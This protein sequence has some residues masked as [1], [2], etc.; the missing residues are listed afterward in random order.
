VDDLG[1]PHRRH[2]TRIVGP[3][4][5]TFYAVDPSTRMPFAEIP[6]TSAEQVA[7]MAED[8]RRALAVE[9]EWREPRVRAQVLGALARLA[10]EHAEALAELECR[11]TGTPPTR[12]RE[13]VAAAVS[14][15]EHSAG[16]RLEG[17]RLQ[18]GPDLL[19]YTLEEPWGV[20]AQVISWRSPL[21]TAA[22][23]AAAA[24]AAGNAV[25]VKPS[26]RASIS[27]LRLAEL[28]ESAGV[29]RGMLQVATG[30]GAV[31]AALTADPGVDHVTFAGSAR[32]AAAVGEA[33]AR[34]LVPCE[35]ELATSPVHVV[36][37]DADLELTVA[38][39]VRSL[40]SR[41]LVERP[42]HETLV[43]RLEA[44]LERLTVGPAHEDPDVG[45][46][47]SGELVRPAIVGGG[48]PRGLEL[49]VAAFDEGSEPV[50]P[51]LAATGVGRPRR[52]RPAGGSAMVWTA[53]LAR[54]HRVAARLRARHV[55][56]NACA[57]NPPPGGANPYARPKTV[58][59]AL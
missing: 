35:L 42:L 24:V 28:A 51:L 58:S 50:G 19:G 18:L 29:P 45:P 5:G 57:S 27:P 43:A 46:L 47:I 10:G 40:G 17:R 37:A 41:V 7:E 44:A 33:C 16:A 1:D 11:D 52:A 9:H 6:E 15:L 23:L 13:E 8:G 2:A 12:A 22:R 26:E 21:A 36:F 39:I 32:A 30:D 20:C 56:V 54:A 38:A 53:D 3:V 25:I 31:G 59:V 34:R 55:T 49:A 4:S 48:E 14:A